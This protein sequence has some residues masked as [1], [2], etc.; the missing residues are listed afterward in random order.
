MADRYVLMYSN[1]GDGS[2]CIFDKDM[3]NVE[4]VILF[5]DGDDKELW[6]DNIKRVVDM[7][8]NHHNRESYFEKSLLDLYKYVKY[9]SVSDEGSR[10]YK[11]IECKLK[12][13][14]GKDL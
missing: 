1:D 13:I 3:E 11:D 4:L 5:E 6:C 12:D 10:S 9:N 2:A 8:N 7:L 14:L